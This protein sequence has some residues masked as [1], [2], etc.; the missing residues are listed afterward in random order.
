[1]SLVPRGVSVDELLGRAVAAINRGDRA[2]ATVLAGQVLAVDCDN[3][4]A[5]DLLA[6]LGDG[7]EIHR[8][9]ILFA[10]LVD[11]ALLSTRAEPESYRLLESRYRDLVLGV[12][13]RFKGHVGSTKG[14]GLLAVFGHPQA[15]EDDVR[16]AVLA[17]LEITREVARLSEQAK[18]RF[19]I[20]VAVRVGVHRGLVYVDTGQDYVYGSAANLAARMSGL[21]PPGAVVVSATVEPLIRGAFDLEV[22]P[23]A[24]SKS[25]EGMVA[26]HQVVGVRAVLARVGRGTLVGR[27]AE[28][29]RLEKSW[30]RAQ[31]G[32]LSTPGVV[33][34]GEPGI[35][36]S[37]LAA[38][39]A[40]LVERSGGMVLE[41]FGS[42]FH[43][44][45]G[46]HPVRILLERRCGIDRGTDQRARLRL[47]KAEIAARSLNPATMVPL[48]APVL[49]IEAGYDPMPAAGRKLYEMIAEAVQTYLVACLGDGAGLVVAENVPWFDPSTMEVLGSLLGAGQG[50]LLVVI[51]GRSGGRLPPGWPV[52][53][54]DLTPLSDEQADALITALNPCMLAE[55]RALVVE[56]YGGVPFYIEQVAG[57]NQTGVPGAR[58]EPLFARL[59][60][61]ANVMA[62][63][64]AAAVIGHQMDRR[65]LCSVV[66]LSDDD[67]D[68]VIDELE[69]ALVL[70]PRGTDRWRFRH[71]LQREVAAELAPPTV[72]RGL[73]AKVADALVGSAGAEAD[74]R[75]VAG[76]Y[77]RAERFDQA[78]TAYQHA[79]T[80]ARRRG[81]LSEARSYLTQALAQLDRAIPGPDRNRHEVFLRSR[82]GLLTSAVEGYQSRD[83]AADF[84][85]C[86]QLVGT[87][88][89]DDE[90]FATLAAV[91]SYYFARAD[92]RRTG[93]ML[94]SLRVGLGEGRQWFRP[95]IEALSGAVAW[96]RGDVDA[97][98]FCLEAATTGQPPAGHH[99]VDAVWFPPNE[100]IA[101]VHL[102]LAH[103]VRG[104]LI[105]AEAELARAARRAAQLGFPRGP[106]M[107]AYAL[108][109]ESWMCVE[110]GQLDRAAVLAADLIDRAARQDFDEYRLWGAAQQHTVRALAALS[111][112]DPDPTALSAHIATM[113]SFLDNLRKFELLTY[114]TYFDAVLGRL[115]IAAG[116]P[117]QARYRLDTA[118]ALA[119]DT[120][121]CF[122]DAELLRL[123]AHTHT[124]PDARQADITAAFELA[125]RQGAT[126]FE[127]R[128]ALDDFELRGEP[129]RATLVDAVS[130][131]PSNNAWPELARA[132]GALS[133]ASPRI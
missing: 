59:R 119:H 52:E 14:D 98:V 87:D 116:H 117:E 132:K 9:T 96:L 7:G 71:E 125:H 63:L 46:L 100:P 39:A 41:L 21:A 64:E 70:E 50:R 26:H 12:V 75:L 8:L 121:L 81:A 79:S 51:T 99:D 120:E 1:M 85:R 95:A 3:V 57:L 118:L 128:A 33:F 113:T 123:K 15:R 105:G 97:A 89:R 107:H 31:A 76:H 103:V 77:E 82:R 34:R 27:D 11:S 69:N 109:V 124:D 17:G 102:A 66:D 13:D 101:H 19:G 133:E 122:Y 86:M 129:A 35:G 10:D 5:T 80:D 25:V 24:A 20:E 54:F 126:L 30:A 90:L 2:A 43:T 131:I 67:V 65:L 94:E 108:F 18:R 112:D 84:E 92:L 32:T 44:D 48:L 130:R 60:A 40:E 62:V 16:R 58:Y 88:L 61:S 111:A 4:D 68:D 55:E 106:F 93:Q 38:A 53:V 74:W 115:L 28:L 36:K 23:S 127:L 29:A 91:A 49:G 42:R 83:A 72:R 56:R 37:R 6:N 45:A 73:H 110:A 78:A 104:D 114:V 22:R 47:L